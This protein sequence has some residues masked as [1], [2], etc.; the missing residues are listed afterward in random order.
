LFKRWYSV[1]SLIVHVAVIDRHSRKA[2]GLT[3]LLEVEH[4]AHRSWAAAGQTRRAGNRRAVLQK[5]RMVVLG[6]LAGQIAYLREAAVGAHSNRVHV[7]GVVWLWNQPRGE[8]SVWTKP[9]R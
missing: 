2:E 3:N 4:D 8:D 5:S 7:V 1:Y 6:N 9:I